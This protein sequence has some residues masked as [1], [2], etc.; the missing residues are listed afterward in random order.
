MRHVMLSALLLLSACGE[1]S[2]DSMERVDVRNSAQLAPAPM[3]ENADM[4]L[5]PPLSGPGDTPA[6]ATAS[7]LAYRH[8][9]GL[10]LPT[11]AVEPTMA[12]HMREC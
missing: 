10:V 9:L 11:A 4:Q 6:P 7:Y 2:A 1:Y 3:V 8:S 12:A 5:Y